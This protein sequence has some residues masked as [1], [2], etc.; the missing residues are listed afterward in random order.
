MCLLLCQVSEGKRVSAAAGKFAE[1]AALHAQGMSQ[2]ALADSFFSSS[3]SD[4]SSVSEEPSAFSF[5]TPLREEGNPRVD[6]APVA[7]QSWWEEFG[8]W[9]SGAIVSPQ[10]R[11]TAFTQPRLILEDQIVRL[12]VFKQHAGLSYA[13]HGDVFEVRH[14]LSACV[15]VCLCNLTVSAPHRHL[16]M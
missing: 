3:A 1:A 16:P 7:D 9:E 13:A 15:S 4:A 14:A 11:V 8:E 2:P 6:L 12:P 10:Q 5:F